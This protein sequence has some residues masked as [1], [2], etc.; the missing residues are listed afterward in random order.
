MRCN[1]VQSPDGRS[2]CGV[3]PGRALHS[4]YPTSAR[5]WLRLTRGL[6]GYQMSPC[7]RVCSVPL[8]PG[9]APLAVVRGTTLQSRLGASPCHC[10]STLEVAAPTVPVFICPFWLL[11]PT[12][13]A[14]YWVVRL[15]LEVLEHPHIALSLPVLALATDQRGCMLSFA[16]Q[17]D[18]LIIISDNSIASSYID[19]P[20]TQYPSELRLR[21]LT[22]APNTHSA[23]CNLF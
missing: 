17:E 20:S 9:Q 11:R 6:P 8:V 12:D 23:S 10:W 1:L 15:R 19:D 3:F 21:S 5:T 4:P 18:K 14:Y 13:D 2:A 16:E 22:G 7:L